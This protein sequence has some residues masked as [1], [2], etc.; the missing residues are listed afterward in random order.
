MCELLSSLPSLQDDGV[1]K[2]NLEEQVIQTNPVLEAF[3]NAKTIRNDN[4]SRFVSLV[5]VEYTSCIR[6][7]LQIVGTLRGHPFFLKSREAGGTC[8][9]RLSFVGSS[10]GVFLSEVPHTS[11]VIEAK[12]NYPKI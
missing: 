4:S 1:K 8:T 11:S 6:W 12:E 2:K 3:G 7:N 9:F 10:I 5:Y